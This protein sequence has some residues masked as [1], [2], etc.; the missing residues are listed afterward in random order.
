MSENSEDYSFK[1]LFSEYKLDWLT[2]F[3]ISDP[4][5]V[6]RGFSRIENDVYSLEEF[7]YICDNFIDLKLLYKN[8]VPYHVIKDF[9]N[10]ENVYLDMDRFSKERI[11]I[12]FANYFN[13]NNNDEPGRGGQYTCVTG[14]NNNFHHY[15]EILPK[16][17]QPE[18]IPDSESNTPGKLRILIR[19]YYEKSFDDETAENSESNTASKTMAEYYK[20]RF[21]VS[22]PYA[23]HDTILLPH[24]KSACNKVCEHWGLGMTN[25]IRAT[26]TADKMHDKLFKMQEEKILL[27]PKLLEQTIKKGESMTNDE[28]IKAEVIL[29]RK[30][31]M[32][33]LFYRRKVYE[34]MFSTE[35]IKNTIVEVEGFILP[36]NK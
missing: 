22:G 9:N 27:Y 34:Y 26:K 21:D 33:N 12:P 16:D 6:S 28:Y 17:V 4:P 24:V 8:R 15:P 19:D 31:N 36:I 11:L 13:Y 10:K 29:N 20:Y 2:V 25:S 14:G 30:I 18:V 23:C 35:D 32:F 3:K 5:P 7:I 1:S